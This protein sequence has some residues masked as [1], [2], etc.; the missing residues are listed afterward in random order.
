[1]VTKLL[2]KMDPS[3]GEIRASSSLLMIE[4][5]YAFHF[6]TLKLLL[7]SLCICY[8]SLLM[9]TFALSLIWFKIWSLLEESTILPTIF[10]GEYASIFPFLL[11]EVGP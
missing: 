6:L 4:I 7:S 11:M 5:D 10:T 3:Y 2:E 1:M 8:Y 9:I